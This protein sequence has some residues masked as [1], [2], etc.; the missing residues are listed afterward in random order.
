MP[1]TYRV[2]SLRAICLRQLSSCYIPP[3]HSAP[4]LVGSPSENCHPVWYGKT[5][6]V[7]LPDNERILRIYIYIYNRL[8]S[9]LACDRQT[10]RHRPRHSPRYAYASRGK[11]HQQSNSI[12]SHKHKIIYIGHAKGKLFNIYSTT[13]TQIKIQDVINLRNLY[14]YRYL[15]SLCE[16]SYRHVPCMMID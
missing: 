7:G 10:D 4:P 9:I 13:R 5:R 1:S 6:M 15:L 3:L 2:R 16:F 11:N 12:S 8:H 14:I